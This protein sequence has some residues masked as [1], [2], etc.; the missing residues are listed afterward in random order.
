MLLG[1]PLAVSIVCTSIGISTVKTLPSLGVLS[2]PM[3][4]PIN[5]ARFFEIARP[6]PVPPNWRVVELSA[7]EN[8]WK[9]RESCSG[10]MPMP[11]SDTKKTKVAPVSL[12]SLT[13]IRTTTSPLAVNLTAFDAKLVRI[14]PRRSGSPI[15]ARGTSGWVENRTSRSF[16]SADSPTNVATDCNTSSRR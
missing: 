12:E 1:N 13:P 2:T 10:V 7:C 14:C 3:V 5:S 6:S 9:S 15:N 11:V 4:P 8:D 16:S